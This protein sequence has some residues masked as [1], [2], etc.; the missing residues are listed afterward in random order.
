MSKKE[1]FIMWFEDGQ[2]RQDIWG[3][4]ELRKYAKQYD[5]NVNEVISN[6]ETKM[7]CDFGSGIVGG[8]FREV[9]A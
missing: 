3:R 6:G 5:F 4:R 7:L 1:L 2:G 9:P 8:V